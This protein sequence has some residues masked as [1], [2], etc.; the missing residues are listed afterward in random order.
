MADRVR[1]RGNRASD[2]PARTVYK[3]L[4]LQFRRQCMARGA[5]CFFCSEPINWGLAHPHPGSFE[6]HH[7][8]PVALRPDLELAVGVSWFPSHRIC[9]SLG[10]AADP[11]G[12]G[13]PG[14]PGS[15]NGGYGTPSEN[16][17]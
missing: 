17:A 14:V 7:N 2:G 1:Q 9:N 4:R 3:R 12:V 13:A 8:P 6:V 15:E 5:V 16:W 11:D 10:Q